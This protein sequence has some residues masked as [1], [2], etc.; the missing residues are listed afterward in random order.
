V[1][2]ITDSN[3]VYVVPSIT[4][5]PAQ[6]ES[7]HELELEDSRGVGP[8]PPPMTLFGEKNLPP[9]LIS[10]IDN[11]IAFLPLDAKGQ[12]TRDFMDFSKSEDDVVNAKVVGLIR[13]WYS[14]TENPTIYFVTNRAVGWRDVTVR[15]LIKIF[16]P[17]SY[18]WNLRMRPANDFV[19]TAGEAKEQ[20][21]VNDIAKKFSVS[22]VWE[23]DDE[24]ILMYKSYGLLVFDA[25]DT[26]PK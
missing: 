19:S 14:L 6:V 21:L 18:R 20:H 10:D 16:P 2:K 3:L 5:I 7:E 17:S 23:D 1:N 25:K 13:A 9:V 15:W 24:C 12:P 11:T 22:Q 8:P 26:W 4:N